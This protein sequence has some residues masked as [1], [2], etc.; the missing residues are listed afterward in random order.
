MMHPS[1]SALVYVETSGDE[2]PA[3]TRGADDAVM[4]PPCGTTASLDQS[5]SGHSQEE[6]ELLDPVSWYASRLEQSRYW[7]GIVTSSRFPY[8]VYWE[9]YVSLGCCV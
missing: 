9:T 2:P 3:E 1:L 4:W 5:S 7:T 6:G 8:C